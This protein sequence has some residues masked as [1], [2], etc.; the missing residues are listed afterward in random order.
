MGTKI[1]ENTEF[2]K[3]LIRGLGGSLEL[4]APTHAPLSTPP[5]AAIFA[6]EGRGN[7]E[8]A[9]IDDV[10]AQFIPSQLGVFWTFF[11]QVVLHYLF[12]N[13]LIFNFFNF[14]SD[15]FTGRDY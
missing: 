7:K 6:P 2:W 10:R 11:S 4:G 12:F 3:S 15:S 9:Y 5:G 8:Y 13:F 14:F 1:E